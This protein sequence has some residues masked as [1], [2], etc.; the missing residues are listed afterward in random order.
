MG[1]RTCGVLTPAPDI[2]LTSEAPTHSPGLVPAGS[3][4]AVL[5]MGRWLDRAETAVPTRRGWGGG[6]TDYYYY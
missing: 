5:G 6:D 3:A 2:L 4:W 1:S